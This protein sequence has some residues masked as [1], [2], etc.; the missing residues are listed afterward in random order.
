LRGVT[1]AWPRVCRGRIGFR[2]KRSLR[3]FRS[4]Q[5]WGWA[6]VVVMSAMSS[7]L[8]AAIFRLQVKW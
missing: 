2:A 4:R 7:G 8:M 1:R 5:S 3:S 6:L